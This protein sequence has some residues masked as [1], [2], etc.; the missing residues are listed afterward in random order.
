MLVS[1]GR[2]I[3]LRGVELDKLIAACDQ[4]GDFVVG[5]P[6][7]KAKRSPTDLDVLHCIMTD[8]AG[9]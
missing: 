7:A 3:L 9:H 5:H 6:L 4:D 2:A 1:R 8:P